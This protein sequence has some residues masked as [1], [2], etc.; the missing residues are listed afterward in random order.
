MAKRPLYAIAL[1]EKLFR[2]LFCGEEC[3]RSTVMLFTIL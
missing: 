2:S 3:D 1:R